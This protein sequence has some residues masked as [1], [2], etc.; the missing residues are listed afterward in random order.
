MFRLIWYRYLLE[1]GSVPAFVVYHIVQHSRGLG[2]LGCIELLGKA[3]VTKVLRYCCYYYTEQY[4]KTD[5]DNL[6]SL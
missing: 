4:A 5:S 6:P 1:L 2:V 3:L